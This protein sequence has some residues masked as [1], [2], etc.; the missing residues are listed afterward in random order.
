MIGLRVSM[1]DHKKEKYAESGKALIGLFN[2]TK[3]LYY[4]AKASSG[5]DFSNFENELTAIEDEFN[6]TSLSNQMLLSDWYA[7]YKF[8]WQHQIDWI[9]E[10]LHFQFVRD[11]LP[12]SFMITLVTLL[13]ATA[14]LAIKLLCHNQ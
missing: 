1:W 3:K 11:K 7:H 6:K 4:Q 2:R 14:I 13:L 12:L 8:F 9:D 10:Q 5:P